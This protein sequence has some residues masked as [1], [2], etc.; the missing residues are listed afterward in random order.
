MIKLAIIVGS[1]RPRRTGEAV[2]K[3]VYGIASKRDDAEYDAEYD[4]MDLKDFP[5]SHRD[6][7][8]PDGCSGSREP[9]GPDP[10]RPSARQ[11]RLAGYATAG[12]S[13][14]ATALPGAPG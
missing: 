9:S 5:L 1:M 8:P 6:E 4:L 11:R 2:A 14:A 10:H 12:R 3:A 13:T 7:A